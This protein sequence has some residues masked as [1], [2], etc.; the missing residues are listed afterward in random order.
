M[1]LRHPFGPAGLVECALYSMLVSL[2]SMLVF[3]VFL[4]TLLCLHICSF[5]LISLEPPCTAQNFFKFQRPAPIAAVWVRHTH[6]QRSRMLCDGVRFVVPQVR[7]RV[8]L[9]PWSGAPL[10]HERGFVGQFIPLFLHHHDCF[11]LSFRCPSVRKYPPGS[12]PARHLQRLP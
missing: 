10:S 4:C 1:H 6:H 8:R 9:C 7:L 3:R 12:L 2:Y 5:D 11:R